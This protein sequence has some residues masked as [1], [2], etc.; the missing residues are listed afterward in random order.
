[1]YV[2]K[3]LPRIKEVRISQNQIVEIVVIFLKKKIKTRQ[4]RNVYIFILIPF[5]KPRD[6]IVGFTISAMVPTV[7]TKRKIFKYLCISSLR[8]A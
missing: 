4:F 6:R 1:M 8:Y 3:P 7:M 5:G 2:K